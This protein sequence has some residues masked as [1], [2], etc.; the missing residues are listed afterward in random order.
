MFENEDRG[1][2]THLNVD[3][4][5]LVIAYPDEKYSVSFKI[6]TEEQAQTKIA[7]DHFEP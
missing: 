5:H 3:H 6:Q 2:V 4:E 7:N 1:F